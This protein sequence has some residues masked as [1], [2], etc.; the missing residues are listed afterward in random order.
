MYVQFSYPLDAKH[1]LMPPGIAGPILRPRSR[2]TP[3]PEGENTEGVRWESYNNTSFI[4]AFVHT[5]T[6]VDTAFHVSKDRPNLGDFMIDDFVFEH[7]LLLE[8]PK[9]DKELILRSDLEP[10]DA[11]LRESD[12]LLIHTGFSRYRAKD[13]EHYIMQQPGFSPKAA[14]YLVSLPNMRCAGAD[15]M[16]IE[17]I[18][19][20]RKADPP[21][22]AHRAFLLSGKKFLI[23][24]DPNIEPLV[25]RK[26]RKAF[27]IPLLFP[28]AEAMMV[29]AFAETD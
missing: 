2:M 25:G 19:E 3:A 29:T 28:E 15:F 16:G 23:L 18:P 7:P 26:L 24:E 17:N 4:D 21:F 1:V 22:P 13:P 12:L 20:G 14:E 8:L 11:S 9:S 10:H 5:G 27:L 6:H